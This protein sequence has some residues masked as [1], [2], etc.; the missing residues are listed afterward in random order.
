MDA[1]HRD[2]AHAAAKLAYETKPFYR[3]TRAMLD[4]VNALD[5]ETLR[6]LVDDDYGIVDI[7][8]EGHSVVIESKEA[9]DAYM[10]RNMA[11]MRAAG[12]Q[13]DSEIV[14]YDGEVGESFG[15]SVVHFR[16]SVTLGGNTLD[17]HCVATI[18]WKNTD[19]GWKE[20]RWHCSLK[21]A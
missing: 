17:N 12:A 20:A 8:P 1:A 5:L 9:W 18:V 15:Y 6:G 14:D 16:Q 10:A 13:L 7:D 11:A 21:S 2:A 19:D 4:A 3:E